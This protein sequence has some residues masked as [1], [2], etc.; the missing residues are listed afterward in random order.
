[1]IQLDALRIAKTKPWYTDA[2]YLTAWLENSGTRY[3]ILTA[4]SIVGWG[5]SWDKALADADRQYSKRV[6][7]RRGEP[8]VR[9]SRRPRSHCCR[10]SGRGCGGSTEEEL[11]DE[12]WHLLAGTTGEK[13]R[14]MCGQEV[15][16][17]HSATTILENV[18]CMACLVAEIREQRENM[19]LIVKI[20]QGEEL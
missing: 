13:S 11:N 16:D 5:F 7:L 4:D 8:K 15:E 19:K 12:L 10:S 3:C 14:G 20:C 1:M 17:N 18:R 6:E 2:I 9:L